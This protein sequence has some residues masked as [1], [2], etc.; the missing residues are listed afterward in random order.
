M[1][2]IRVS[3]S[4]AWASSPIRR[5]DALEG[6]PAASEQGEAAFTEAAGRAQQRVVGL[7]VR[8]EVMPVGGLLDRRLDALACAFVAGVGQGGQVEVGGGPVQRADAPASR[9]TVRSCR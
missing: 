5:C 4:A 6:S 3:T 8:G 7:V 2:S 9:A 1:F